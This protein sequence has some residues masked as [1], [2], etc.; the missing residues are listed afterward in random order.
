MAISIQGFKALAILLFIL[1]GNLAYSQEPDIPPIKK[2]SHYKK[3]NKGKM[4]IFWGW[5]RGYYSKSDI[6][7]T[8]DGYDFTL[9]D[10]KAQDR[11]TPFGFDPYLNPGSITIPQTNFRI[12]YYFADHYSVAI[13]VD[14]M[15]YFVINDQTVKMKGFVDQPG[16]EFNGI[17]NDSSIVITQQFLKFEHSDGLNYINVE[18]DRVDDILSWFHKDMDNLELNLSEGV[19]AGALYPKTNATLMGN[20][21][22]DDFHTSGYGVSLKVGLNITFYKYFF[23]QGEVKGGYINMPDILTTPFASDRADQQFTY[24]MVAFEFGV[25]FRIAN[26]DKG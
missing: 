10:T 26:R 21:R 15:K 19:S 14:H 8:G 23:L 1:S 2:T 4:F 11:Q 16:N 25:V 22:H 24:L 13:G 5:N 3:A 17:Y 6:H 18:V 7:F 12:G 9:K 20:P